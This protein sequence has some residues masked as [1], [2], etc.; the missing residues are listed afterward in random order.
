MTGPRG[1]RGLVLCLLALTAVWQTSTWFFVGGSQSAAP[2]G[3]ALRSVA[4][5]DVKDVTTEVRGEEGT[6]TY[7]RFFLTGDQE[8]SPWHDLPLETEENGVY[9]MVTEIPKNTKSKMEIATKESSN[10][11]AQ[12]TKK[13]KLR[14]YHGPIYWN[15]GYLPQTWEDPNV[16]HPDL[17]VKGDN[18]PVDVVE[19]GSRTSLQG[20]ISK[21]KVL[22][23]L[24]MIDD[25]E[26]DWKILAIAADDPMASE[27]ENVADVDAKMPGVISG[28]REWFRW[29]KTPDG[30]PLNAFGFDEAPLD[31]GAALEVIS[32]THGYW[33]QLRKSKSDDLW[34][35]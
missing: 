30:K 12:D 13:G 25:G 16:E 32:E 11:I 22:G 35:G 26:L 5:S 1:L 7:R 2:R 4:I 10:P 19:I 17:K 6:S 28:I 14:E 29:Y 3:V 8:I 27:L 21:V 20:E 23:A 24:A 34:V 31:Q 15:Y 18:D 9:W 33:K